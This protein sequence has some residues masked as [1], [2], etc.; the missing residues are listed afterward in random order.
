MGI[1]LTGVVV[2]CCDLVSVLVIC[3]DY[4]GFLLDEANLPKD[5]TAASCHF[6]FF[7]LCILI[8][9][10]A[11]ISFLDEHRRMKQ[12]IDNVYYRCLW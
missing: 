12:F 5:V 10:C 9:V 7:N 3:Q 4:L 11:I 2:A 8:V 1:L 6:V